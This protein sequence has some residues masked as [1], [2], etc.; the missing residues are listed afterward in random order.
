[1]KPDA[2]Y[3]LIVEHLPAVAYAQSARPPED[4]IYLSPAVEDMLGYSSDEFTADPDLWKRLIHEDDRDRVLAEDARSTRTGEPF[5]SEFRF[6]ARDGRAVWVRN[7]SHLIRDRD[8]A[9]QMWIGISTDVTDRRM[10]EQELHETQARYRSLVESI[11]A[12][13]YVD[14]LDDSSGVGYRTIYVSPQ[15]EQL[16]GFPPDAFVEHPELWVSLYHPDDAT[17]ART[18]DDE[19]WRTGAPLSH[20]HRMVAKDGRVVWVQDLASLIEVGEHV[21]M[22]QGFLVDVT[23]RKRAEELTTAREAAERASRSTNELL[24][25]M[26]HE[27]RTP[28]NAILGFGQLLERSEL[29]PADAE[30]AEQIVEAGR[31]LLVLVDEVLEISRLQTGRTPLSIEAVGIREVVEEALALTRPL[32]ADRD[33]RLEASDAP[34]TLVTAD[35]GS[36]KRVL[37]E[38]LGNG[39]LYNHPGGTVQVDWR[40]AP[41]EVVEI[42]V[43]D[44]GEGIPQDGLERLFEPFERL[45]RERGR[46]AGTGLGLALARRLVEGM[47]GRIDARS[48]PGRGSVFRVTLA[49]AEPPDKTAGTGWATARS[50]VSRVV[51]QIEDNPANVRLVERVLERRPDLRLVSTNEGRTGLDLARSEAPD[52]I[53]LDLNLPDMSG[54]EVLHRLQGRPATRAI[55]VVLLSADTSE[56]KAARLQA[57][58]ARAYL[59]K[60]LDIARFLEVVDAIVGV[61]A[62][63]KPRGR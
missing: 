8:G 11:P 10:V 31:R 33:V 61:E 62:E 58:G 16:L 52:L 25:R 63:A 20:E 47:G 60:P 19:H 54:E 50:G 49:T 24:S 5:V 1:M 32:A 48:E 41:R 39:V 38:L 14:V 35:R 59:V 27:L 21:R 30:S 23:D 51:L 29:V 46:T 42:E 4:T 3:R 15:I 40:P 6:V 36:L 17:E 55:P 26:S 9:P 18:A 12:V 43:S 34:D 22:S 2:L 13:T 45:G 56:S 7:E 57:A 44:S 37:L 28:L 53:L